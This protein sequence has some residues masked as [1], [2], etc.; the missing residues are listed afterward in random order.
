MTTAD[1][2]IQGSSASSIGVSPYGSSR[3]TML[4]TTKPPQSSG[5]AIIPR[6]QA[7]VCWNATQE[8]RTCPRRNSTTHE[9]SRIYSRHDARAFVDDRIARTCLGNARP[10]AVPQRG[11]FTACVS[12]H[13]GESQDSTIDEVFSCSV[14][15]STTGVR[16]TAHRRCAPQARW[17][18][19]TNLHGCHYVVLVPIRPTLPRRQGD[20]YMF[21]VKARP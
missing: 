12:T 18:L 3:A 4:P 15:A 17:L 13:P 9:Y 19:H 1:R 20:Q 6:I 7:E 10:Q 5:S 2:T 14:R 16:R 8:G 21:V 11:R